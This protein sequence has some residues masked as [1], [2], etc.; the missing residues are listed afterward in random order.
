M[1][2][3][4]K[5]ALPRAVNVVVVLLR[6]SWTAA[7]RVICRGDQFRCRVFMLQA[8][9]AFILCSSFYFASF[10]PDSCEQLPCWCSADC[11]KTSL[12]H[13]LTHPEARHTAEPQLRTYVDISLLSP[14]MNGSRCQLLLRPPRLTCRLLSAALQCHSVMSAN[15][16]AQTGSPACYFSAL[17]FFTPLFNTV[18][19]WVS[20]YLQPNDQLSP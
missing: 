3:R 2:S 10:L 8:A 5:A 13:T 1:C 18:M 20:L 19:Q 4:T 11:S 14:W 15:K 6:L 12:S 17:T 9:G 7:C 16:S